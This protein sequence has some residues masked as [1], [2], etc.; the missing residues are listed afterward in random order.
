MD[1]IRSEVNND[2]IPYCSTIVLHSK[3]NGNVNS[4][5]FLKKL[6]KRARKARHGHSGERA[7]THSKCAQ[8]TNVSAPI[9]QSCCQDQITFENPGAL[10][11]NT[12][13]SQSSLLYGGGVISG[14]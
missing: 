13:S 14:E 12:R 6:D 2:V 9:A 11:N 3:R 7:S 8:L 5:M 4:D 10:A 1:G